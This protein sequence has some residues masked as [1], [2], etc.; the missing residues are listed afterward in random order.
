VALDLRGRQSNLRFLEVCLIAAGGSIVLVFPSKE[1]R[2]QQA[3]ARDRW[4]SAAGDA[5]DEG[6]AVTS[7]TERFSPRFSAADRGRTTNGTGIDFD[8]AG[9]ARACMKRFLEPFLE[10]TRSEFSF[11]GKGRGNWRISRADSRG[12]SGRLTLRLPDGASARSESSD[13]WD[14]RICSPLHAQHIF[15]YRVVQLFAC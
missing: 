10:A 11:G 6:V 4:G 12:Q 15:R 13:N 8:T 1:T 3:P 5:E 14:L 7:G 2:R 9:F